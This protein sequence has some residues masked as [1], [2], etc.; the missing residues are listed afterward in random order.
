MDIIPITSTHELWHPVQVYAEACPWRAGPFLA[1]AMKDQQ[2]TEWERMFVA[3][4]GDTILC[5]CTL[6]KTD[7]IPDVP[8]CPYIGYVF[9]DEHHR[10]QRLSEQMIRC[11]MAY[12][13]GQGFA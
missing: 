11:A 8:Y 4:E 7:C 12:A 9:V 1:K 3:Y 6:A 10:G 2:F 13:K 5:F